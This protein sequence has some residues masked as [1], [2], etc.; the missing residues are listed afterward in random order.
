MPRPAGRGSARGAE[1]GGQRRRARLD[2]S[3]RLLAA[4]APR[5]HVR[6]HHG[7]RVYL[8]TL[9]AELKRAGALGR[10]REARQ[11]RRA[12]RA[13]LEGASG[14]TARLVDLPPVEPVQPRGDAGRPLELLRAA[15]TGELARLDAGLRRTAARE[16][17]SLLE[18][19]SGM[20]LAFVLSAREVGRAHVLEPYR[21]D[22][23]PL[24]DE[25]S[26][27]TRAGGRRPYWK[28][29]QT[30]R[31]GQA[32]LTERAP[33]GGDGRLSSVRAWPAIAA[34]AVALAAEESHAS[35]PSPGA[36]R[37]SR[38]STACPTR[39]PGTRSTSLTCARRSW[40]DRFAVWAPRIVGD[41]TALDAW[42]R[43]Q[44]PRARFDLSSFPVRHGVRASRPR[45]SCCRR[46]SA[47]SRRSSTVLAS[48][49]REQRL[50][51][52]GE[53]LP[54]LLRRADE[55]GRD[56]ECRLH[57]A[58][59]NGLLPGFAVALLET[60]RAEQNDTVRPVVAVHEPSTRSTPSPARR[61]APARTA[62][63]ATS[64]TT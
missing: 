31:S 36:A 48:A 9:V 46:S 4:L 11:R 52:A 20:A 32:H 64:R 26:P 57:G 49:R 60:C 51:R 1:D 43:T 42:W 18:V 29:S 54:R 22:L 55:P 7:S 16:R 53:G 33:R 34:A 58:S 28:R 21:E 62:T 47:A 19:S 12:A 5:R 50:H 10:G 37:R 17:R 25:D 27:P 38:P 45:T 2:R 23:R 24:R 44:I 3:V 41:V 61:R 30:L 39:R 35:R 15:D 56:A 8:D 14:T 63:S 6:C 13:A 40:S 59:R